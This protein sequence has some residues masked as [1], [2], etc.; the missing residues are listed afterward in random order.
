MK[1]DA[2][3]IGSYPNTDL[4]KEVL[5]QCILALN[6]SFDVLLS[7]HYPVDSDIQNLVKYYTFDTFNELIEENGNPIV[8]FSNDRFYLQTKHQKNY[9]YSAYSCMINAIRLLSNKYDYFYYINGDTLIHSDEVNKLVYLKQL[10]LSQGKKSVFFKEHLGMVEAKIFFSE[11][12]YFTDHIAIVNSKQEFIKYTET[13]S[14]PYVPYVLESFF[15]ERIDKHTNQNVHIVHQNL[16]HFFSKSEI[17][18]L[19][20]FN[21][22]P[23]RRRDY[24]IYLV[25]EKHSNKIFFVYS[26]QTLDFEKKTINIRIDDESFTLDNG[27]YSFYKEV[28]VTKDVILLEIE[29]VSNFY[30]VKDILENHESYIEFNHA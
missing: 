14:E 18:V 12:K 9:A 23:E 25:K 27:L 2:V 16:G 29:G 22:K 17:D 5:K 8:W 15:S 28:P 13:F 3:I 7:T 4:S 10:M 26:N 1:R 20:S 24:S 30:V 19:N 11:T 21:G 6:Q